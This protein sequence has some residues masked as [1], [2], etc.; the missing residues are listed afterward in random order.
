[1]ILIKGFA[2]LCGF[3]VTVSD[4]IWKNRAFGSVYL[5]TFENHPINDLYSFST[6]INVD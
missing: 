2:S 3:E 5:I 6:S 1:M 4:N